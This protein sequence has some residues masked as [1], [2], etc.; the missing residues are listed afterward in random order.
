M[1]QGFC[2]TLQWKTAQVLDLKLLMGLGVGGI[3][4]RD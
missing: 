4:N 1:C 2:C 3:L